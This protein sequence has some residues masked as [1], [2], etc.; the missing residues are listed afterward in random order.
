MDGIVIAIS[1]HAFLLVTL[2]FYY[3][4]HIKVDL[5]NSKHKLSFFA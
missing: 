3:F 5:F 1:N 4:A 2:R